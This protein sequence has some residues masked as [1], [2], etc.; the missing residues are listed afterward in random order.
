MTYILNIETTTKTCSVV[1][2]KHTNVISKKESFSTYTH[3]ENL[4]IFIEEVIKN[5]PITLNKIDAIAVSKGPGSYMGLRIGVSAAKGL[6][7]ALNIPL[8]GIDTLSAM[9]QY[10]I[11]KTDAKNALF[12][13]MI[14]AR[15]ME[16]YCAVYDSNNQC[17]EQTQAKIIE[18]NAFEAYLTHHDIY[19][20]GDG[21]EKCMSILNRNKNAHFLDTYVMSAEALILSAYQKYNTAQFEDLAY[22]EPFYLKDFIPGISKVKGLQ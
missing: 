2:S 13:P 20:F 21:A 10:A 8:L 16:V 15:R 17:I 11:Q 19:F 18:E 9:S 3:A 22:F 14:D 4:T 12:C 5:S 1:L 6:C 7:Y